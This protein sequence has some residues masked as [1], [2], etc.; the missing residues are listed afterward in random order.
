MATRCSAGILRVAST[1]S[2]SAPSRRTS[3]RRSRIVGRASRTSGRSSRRN[4]ARSF[5]AG[6][7]SATSTS[8]S[9]SVARRF[10]NVVLAR[11]SVVGSS[12]SARESATF[13]AAIAPAVAFA[14]PTRPARS[15]RRSATAVTAREELTMKRVSAPSSSVTW[16]DQHARGR[17]QRVEVLGRLADLLALAL[18]LGREALD[19]VLQVAAR[20]LVE[21]V[22]D[23]VEVDDRWSSRTGRAWR[24]RRSSLL[25]S[26]A[27]RQRDVAVG[28][29]RQRGQADDGL[30]CPRAAARRAP[31][32]RP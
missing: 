4:G 13:S 9:S 5:V 14:L 22:E 11:R 12:S 32:P 19:D 15:S 2:L 23:L 28:D 26:G 20:L 27:E 8:R 1:R 29:A 16:L 24:R 21:R 3:V 31:R 25:V 18:V 7:D 17:Q 10:T 6:L 30:R